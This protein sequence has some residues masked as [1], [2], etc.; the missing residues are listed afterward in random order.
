[1]NEKTE[2]VNEN[3]IVQVVVVIGG[4]SG[5]HEE[6]LLE[7]LIAVAR[8]SYCAELFSCPVRV[9]WGSIRDRFEIVQESFASRL[10]FVQELF[11]G[12]FGVFSGTK[13]ESFDRCGK[14]KGS[15]DQMP[16]SAEPRKN[17]M[18]GDFREAVPS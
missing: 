9:D 15:I 13:K 14:E 18:E 11:W 16:R 10:G 7:F 3:R 12:H 1:M 8:N 2:R 17:K 6:L 5:F 4:V